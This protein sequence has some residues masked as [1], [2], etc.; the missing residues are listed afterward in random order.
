MASKTTTMGD[1]TTDIL[2]K[3]IGDWGYKPSSDSSESIEYIEKENKEIDMIRTTNKDQDID[4]IPEYHDI[5]H[6]YNPIKI[7]EQD[8]IKFQRA[9]EIGFT[10]LDTTMEIAAIRHLR[11]TQD[12]INHI[13][14]HPAM[15]IL[16][17]MKPESVTLELLEKLLAQKE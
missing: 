2:G 6:N 8:P 16:S 9:N 3:S 14:V 15:N 17:K 10:E 1:I 5:V 13:L 11:L 4:S 7:S 12:Q